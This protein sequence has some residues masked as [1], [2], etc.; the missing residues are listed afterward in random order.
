MEEKAKVSKD[1]TGLGAKER[2]SCVTGSFDS[3]SPDVFRDGDLFPSGDA[4]QGITAKGSSVDEGIRSK[5][6]LKCGL[7]FL[8]PVAQAGVAERELEVA[9]SSDDAY[10]GIGMSVGIVRRH[11]DKRNYYE[12][13]LLH[14]G[15]SMFENAG[16][17]IEED[18]ARTSL[19]NSSGDTWSSVSTGGAAER[20]TM[21]PPTR[22]IP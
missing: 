17:L 22:C 7:H 21:L 9:L 13:A 12:G 19:V 2:R 20:T 6:M 8:D 3:W 10:I 1:L 15:L 14:P 16:A 11:K 4:H 18:N 5:V